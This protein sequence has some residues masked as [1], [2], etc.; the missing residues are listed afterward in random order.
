MWLKRHG[1]GFR[2]N[3]PRPTDNF[4][5][6]VRMCPVHS[7]KVP[8]AHQRRPEGR[9]NVIEFVKDLQIQGPGVRGQRSV[10]GRFC[11]PLIPGP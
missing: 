2:P 1:H 8:H 6:H 9:G 4:A 5:Q 10:V 11:R 3:L 7:V